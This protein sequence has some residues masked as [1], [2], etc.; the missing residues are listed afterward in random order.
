MTSKYHSNIYSERIIDN[1]SNDFQRNIQQP[2][3]L[4]IALFGNSGTGKTTTIKQ[5]QK[6]INHSEKLDK[7]NYRCIIASV[8][9]YPTIKGLISNILESL[10]DP[11]YASQHNNIAKFTGRLIQYL[12][13]RETKILV[14]DEF[15]HFAD[16]KTVRAQKEVTD[17][18][19]L[20][21]DKLNIIL[22][23][24]GL[25][26]ASNTIKL[27]EQLS[28]RFKASF[29]QPHFDWTKRTEQTEYIKIVNR[30][31]SDYSNIDFN[32]YEND[33]FEYRTYCATGGLLRRLHNFFEELSVISISK[34]ISTYKVFD[35]A[36][37]KSS[38]K[39]NYFKSSPFSPDFNIKILPKTLQDIRRYYSE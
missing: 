39:K 31:M 15:Q 22:L 18:L 35:K 19:K 26:Y 6:H 13:E 7:N 24:S 20:L 27:N 17:W 34:K 9:G 37:R 16:H 10:D 14:L 38:F 36:F 21:I 28:T 30:F 25:P 4:Y 5:L 1:L 2:K 23:V 32:I 3:P 11:M 12:K 33:S 29:I 8:P